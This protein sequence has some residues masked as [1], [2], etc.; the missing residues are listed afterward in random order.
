MLRTLDSDDDI[1]M[2]AH[3]SLYYSKNVP[4]CSTNSDVLFILPDLSAV[5][6][7]IGSERSRA[8]KG[9]GKIDCGGEEF[10]LSQTCRTSILSVKREPKIISTGNIDDHVD[11]ELAK[12]GTHKL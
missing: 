6:A 9:F 11:Y 8:P 5:R 12:L 7:D 1:E 3:I 2:I 4:C 10:I